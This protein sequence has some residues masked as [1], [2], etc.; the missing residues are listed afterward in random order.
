MAK[1][2]S[3]L[4]NITLSADADQITKARARARE[5]DS[6][7]NDAFRA[8]LEQFTRPITSKEEYLS[9][10]HEMNGLLSGSHFSRDQANER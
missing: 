5:N 10:M 1:R 2:Q 4:K 3:K 8:W 6:T 7:L 9:L